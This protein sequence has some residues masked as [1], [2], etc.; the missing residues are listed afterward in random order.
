[1]ADTEGVKLFGFQDGPEGFVFY[2][3]DP[4]PI[5]F[6]FLRAN[7]GRGAGKTFA[8]AVRSTVYAC[9]YPESI[10]MVV[11]L[12]T[13]K[14]RDTIL[15]TLRSVFR[16]FGMREGTHYEYNKTERTLTFLFNGSQMFMRSAEE[17]E[18]LPGPSLAW[19]WLDEYRKMPFRVWEALLP[20]LRQKGFPHQAWM[21]ST[22]AGRAHWSRMIWFPKAYAAEFDVPVYERAAGTYRSYRAKTKDNP[23]NGAEFYSSLLSTYGEGTQLARQELEGEEVVMEDLVYPIW[24]S[25]RHVVHPSKWPVQKFDKVLAGV[26]FGFAVPSAIVVGAQ[27]HEGNHYLL[28]EFY[29]KGMSE[30]ALIAEAR[31]LK[32]QWGIRYF[33]ADSADPRWIQSFRRAG[34]PVVPARKTVGS[35]TDPSSGIGLCYSLLARKRPDGSPLLWVSPRCAN[36][37]RE[38]E[39][40]VRDDPAA[41]RDP[42]ERPRKHNDHAV[43]AWRYLETFK[44]LVWGHGDAT[45]PKTSAVRWVA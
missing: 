41:T 30:D 4:E 16:A 5:D 21:T 45:R 19:F 43:D 31:R 18:N 10:G 44:A 42:S 28:D 15:P 20:T 40:Y 23:H 17:P 25:K 2:G 26:D 6:L 35:V 36:F 3:L 33:V 37:R 8:G 9:K 22:P 34:L 27:D 29:R 7:C 11:G 14:V 13:D 1:M 24:D 32:A 38:I 12:T 39:N